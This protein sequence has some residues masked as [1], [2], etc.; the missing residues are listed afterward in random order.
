MGRLCLVPDF[1]LTVNI[2][3]GIFFS[4][5]VLDNQKNINLGMILSNNKFILLF[6]RCDSNIAVIWENA[7]S[8][9]TYFFFKKKKVYLKKKIEITYYVEF[10]LKYFWKIRL[11]GWNKCGKGLMCVKLGD[12]S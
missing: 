2:V 1:E 12:D 6:N 4:V 8:N 9:P 10:A 5:F 11:A 3:I 7:L